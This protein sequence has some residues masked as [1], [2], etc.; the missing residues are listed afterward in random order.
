MMYTNRDEFLQYIITSKLKFNKYDYRF[1]NNLSMLT[2]KNRYVTTNQNTLFEKVV[3]KYKKQ[4]KYAGINNVDVL[5][6]PWTVPIIASTKEHTEAFV[7]IEN[8]KL[9]LRLPFSKK[10]IDEFH[11]TDNQAYRYNNDSKLKWISSDKLYIGEYNAYNLRLIK[12][13]VPKYF[14]LNTCDILSSVYNELKSYEAKYQNPTYVKIQNNYYVVACN[15]SL[16]LATID[17]PFNNSP[18]TLLSLSTYGIH[19]DDSV[20]GNDEFLSFAGSFVE[21]FDTENIDKLIVYLKELNFDNLIFN[22]RLGRNPIY[23]I[24]VEKLSQ[25]FTVHRYKYSVNEIQYD[26]NCRTALILMGL[27]LLSQP[28]YVA[29]KVI[30][31]S[32]S[33]QINL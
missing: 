16:Y 33:K 25:N 26:P 22:H 17:I 9:K 20:T 7:E 31:L 28:H 23:T 21:T 15:N 30:Q 19:I 27:G 32:S 29:D 18:N 11:D 5:N 3:N 12:E 10:F 24:A 14:V 13:L 6:L 4:L 2:S 1:L 8:N